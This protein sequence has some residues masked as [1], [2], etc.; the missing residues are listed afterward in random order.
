MMEIQ[1]EKIKQLEDE[2]KEHEMYKQMLIEFR[3]LKNTIKVNDIKIR[4]AK[5]VWRRAGII[6]E[7][8]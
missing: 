5:S 7:E 6:W 4:A 2:I 3:E 8:E 1:Q